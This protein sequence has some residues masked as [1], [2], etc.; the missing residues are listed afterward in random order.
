MGR[1]AE[2]TVS[3]V[4][5][6]LRQ[7]TC[8]GIAL[9]ATVSYL[10]GGWRPVGAIQ[11]LLTRIDATVGRPCSSAR[12]PEGAAQVKGS[13]KKADQSGRRIS[14]KIADALFCFAL[15]IRRGAYW[16]PVV[17]EGTKTLQ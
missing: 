5:E 9:W 10:C 1:S 15:T 13:S 6:A 8:G 3:D 14:R 12:R 2:T 16:L 17:R 7:A 4:G 11:R